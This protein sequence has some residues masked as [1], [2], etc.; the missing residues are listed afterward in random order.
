MNLKITVPENLNFQG[1]FDDI[2]NNYTNSWHM[3]RVKTSNFGTLFE[4][5]YNLNL[6]QSINQK[7]FLD[8]LRCRNGNLNIALT[9]K[10]YEDKIYA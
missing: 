2:L 6:K 9:S 7:E 3:K 4:V 5:V 8:E 10:E 1:L